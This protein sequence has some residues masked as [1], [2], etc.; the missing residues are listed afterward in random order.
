MR[1]DPRRARQPRR[2]CDAQRLP[3]PAAA[4]WSRDPN[5]NRTEVAFDALGMVVGTAVMGKPPPAPVEGD[6]LDRLRRRPDRRRSSTASSTPPTRTPAPRRCC[7]DATTRH[8]LRPRSP[9]GARK[10][11]DPTQRQPAVR[12]HARPRD[13]RQRPAAGAAD[14]RSSISFSYSDGFGREIQKKI[15]AEPG[16][17]VEGGPV[18]NPRWVGS[19]WT[20]FNNKGKPVRQ[21]EPFFS[22]THRFEFGVQRRRQPGAVLRPGRAR[23]RHAAPEPHL[24]EG[25]LRPLAADDLRRQRHLRAAQRRRPATRAPTP[26]SA[27][28]SPSTSRPSRASLADLARA[29]HRRRARARRAATPPPSAAAHADTPTTAHFDALGRPFLTV[30]RN[31]VVCAGHDLDGT[32]DSFATRVELDIE[33]NQRAVRDADRSRTATRSAA[34]SCA[35]TTTCSATASTSSAWRRARAGCSTTWPASRSAPGT[36]AA[37]PSRTDYDALRR[38]V[39]Q[40]VR[41]TGRRLRPAHAEPRHCWS[42]EIEYG[43]AA[44]AE[45]RSAQ[46]A[47]AAS[48]GTST[49]A[50]VVTN[51]RLDVNGNPIEAYDFK[52]NLLRSTRRLVSDDTAIPDWTAEPRRSTPRASRQHALRRAQ[53]PQ[54]SPS[55]RRTAAG[56]ATHTDDHSVIQPVFNEAN[57]LE[58]VDVWLDL[59]GEPAELLDPASRAPSPVGV[60]NIDYDAKGQ[61]R[62]STTR[63]APARHYGVRPPTLTTRSPSDS[64][65]LAHR[66]RRRGLPRRLTRSPPVAGWPGCQ[67]AE[68]ALHLRPRRQHHPHPATTRSRPSSSATSAS[69]RATTTPTTPST[70]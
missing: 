56:P 32:E 52:G 35:T 13:P 36:A 45:R 19:G 30:A 21:Y 33:G 24:R 10:R 27:A 4:R 60:A 25:R 68:P 11:P 5:R 57:L 46:P 58:R 38:P 7:G 49:Q 43:E 66:A 41:G 48:T 15:Q 26:T 34:S 44:L 14:S 59:R 39:E 22:D 23:R 54:S 29:A 28:T 55:T 3:R 40:T 18:V 50:G 47:H 53:P 51:A 1:R 6:S 8:R 65:R 17:L 9:T 2:R 64:T 69:S 20:I 12:R 37:T 67:R 31:R 63:T 70:G 42:S 16:P 62:A 61:R